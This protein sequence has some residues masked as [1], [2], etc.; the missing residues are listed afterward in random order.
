MSTHVLVP[1]DGSNPAWKALDY[2]IETFAGE[3]ITAFHVV[4][5]AVGMYAGAEGGYYDPE[6]YDRAQEHG[7]E[8]CQRA[9]ERLE[10]A[11]VLS[12]TVFDGVVE[13]GRP[14]RAILEY[15]DEHG[16]DHL[17]IGSHGRKGV[18]RILLGSVAES[19][20]RRAPVPV[21]IVR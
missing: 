2:A 18:S 10:E 21:T 14:E 9:R 6:A 8:L 20:A 16:V 4:D 13:S 12:E 5:P 11:G 7:E 19:V 15:A 3:H 17:V 1:I